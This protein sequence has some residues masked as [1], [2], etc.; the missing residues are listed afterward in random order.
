MR[1]HWTLSSRRISQLPSNAEVSGAVVR[2]GNAAR[3]YRRL[4]PTG[5]SRV[6][7]FSFFGKERNS[8]ATIRKKKHCGTY[9]GGNSDVGKYFFSKVCWVGVIVT[10][11]FSGLFDLGLAVNRTGVS[12]ANA[13]SRT[14]ALR[15]EFTRSLGGSPLKPSL[16]RRSSNYCRH[17]KI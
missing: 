11:F 8:S 5:Y 2:R 12:P 15:T 10:R 9:G 17:A 13:R 3:V 4:S 14:W 6:W 1:R 7:K 16:H